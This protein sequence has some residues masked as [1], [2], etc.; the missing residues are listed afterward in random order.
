MYY[1]YSQEIVP[2]IFYVESFF[3]LFCALYMDRWTMCGQWK[4]EICDI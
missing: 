4:F 3:F 2:K 1:P